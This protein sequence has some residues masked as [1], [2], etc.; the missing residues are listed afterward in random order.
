MMAILGVAFV[1]Y[2]Y[3]DSMMVLEGNDT[4]RRLGL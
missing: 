4:K 2:D 1:H 3:F